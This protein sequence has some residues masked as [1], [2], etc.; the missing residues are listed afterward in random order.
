MDYP[1]CWTGARR[2]LYDGLELADPAIVD[3]HKRLGASV[4]VT[5]TYVRD[6]DLLRRALIQEP[7]D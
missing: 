7:A 3:Q 1:V 4:G 6:R 5:A 2:P